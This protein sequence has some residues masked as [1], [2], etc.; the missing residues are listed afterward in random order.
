MDQWSRDEAVELALAFLAESY[1][2]ETLAGILLLAEHLLPALSGDDIATLARPFERGD[3]T[4]WS[5]C[6]W[7]AVKVLARLLERADDARATAEALSAWRTADSLWQRRA[8]AV[9]FVGVARRARELPWLPELI[10]EVCATNTR[11]P[12]RFSQTSVGWVLRDLS[13]ADPGRVRAFVEQHLDLLSREARYMATERLDPNVRR[14][15]KPSGA[16]R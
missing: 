4:E 9:S 16:R 14:R 7:Y 15:F 13:K 6:D 12:A 11:D 5:T 3:I 10:F 1:A 8:A 2:E